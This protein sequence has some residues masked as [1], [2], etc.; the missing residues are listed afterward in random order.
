M[1]QTVTDTRVTELKEEIRKMG[2]Q[3][4]LKRTGVSGTAG[5][6]SAIVSYNTCARPTHGKAICPGEKVKGYSCRLMGYFRGSTACKRKPAE[7]KA[8]TKGERANQVDGLEGKSDRDSIGWVSEDFIW[9]AG[10]SAKSKIAMVQLTS[11]DG[12]AR[13]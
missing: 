11:L 5:R 10:I 2:K 12:R 8:K 6:D 1:R 13:S 4:E 3:I 9:A 7:D